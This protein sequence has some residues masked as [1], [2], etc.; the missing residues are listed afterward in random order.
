VQTTSVRLPVS[1]LVW[2]TKSYFHEIRYR[3]SR[4]EVEKAWV[5]WKSAQWH[6]YFGIHVVWNVA[7][8]LR[9]SSY[10]CFERDVGPSLSNVILRGVLESW[11]LKTQ[12][13]IQN[14]AVTTYPTT[15]RRV[16]EDLDPQEH[17]R[18]NVTFVC[19]VTFIGVNEFH[20]SW[21][22]WMKLGLGYLDTY[23]LW[24]LWL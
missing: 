14:S 13:C 11:H 22:I 10:H 15:Q 20:I 1:D 16:R 9:G 17:R 6:S 4:R 3:S 21:P 23:C 5:S 7:T 12:R 18:E 2:T 8:C 19:H 24:E